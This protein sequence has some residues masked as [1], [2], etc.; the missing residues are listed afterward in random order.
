MAK[1][2]IRRQVRELLPLLV[3]FRSPMSDMENPQ[4]VGEDART[5][6]WAFS[7]VYR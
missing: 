6:G 7:S 4:P 2:N 3:L 1:T 5:L